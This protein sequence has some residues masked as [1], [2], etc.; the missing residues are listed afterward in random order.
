M[1]SLQQTLI[2]IVET[3]SIPPKIRNKTRVS[4]FTTIIQHFSGSPSYNNQRRKAN[5]RNPDQKRR[6]LSLFA[7]DRTLYLKVKVKSLS[8]V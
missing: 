4:N 8:R 5:K 3:E 2:S 7:D 1:I 6:K